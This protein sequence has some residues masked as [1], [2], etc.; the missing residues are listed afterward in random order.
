MK[1]KE[2]SWKK[3]IKKCNKKKQKSEKKRVIHCGLML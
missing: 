3:K 1:K 2:E